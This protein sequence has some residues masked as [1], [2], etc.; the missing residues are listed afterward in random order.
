MA[1]PGGVGEGA[2]PVTAG[3]GRMARGLRNESRTSERVV[4]DVNDV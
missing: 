4:R 2:D 3:G 1:K